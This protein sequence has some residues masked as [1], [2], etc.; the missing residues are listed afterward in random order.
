MAKKSSITR[1]MKRERL[2]KQFSEKRASLKKIIKN[3]QTSLDDRIA[4]VIQLA[5][6][7]RNSAPSRQRIRCKISGRARGVYRKFLLSRIMLRKYASSGH[8]P[9]M[10]KSSW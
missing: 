7:P 10:V 6:L 2:I 4:S 9:G 8:I 5:K 3:R 1:E